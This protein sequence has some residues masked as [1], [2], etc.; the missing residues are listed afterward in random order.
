MLALW[1]GLGDTIISVAWTLSYEMYFYLLFGLALFL[2]RRVGLVL[3]ATILILGVGIGQGLGLKSPNP[4]GEALYGSELLLFLAGVAIGRVALIPRF[5][6]LAGLGLRPT[7]LA[8]VAAILLLAS[9]A[10]RT[11][12]MPPL[13]AYGP[14][15]VLLV[16]AAVAA[17]LFGRVHWTINWFSSLGDSSYALYLSHILTTTLLNA[18]VF[19]FS[20]FFGLGVGTHIIPLTAISVLLAHIFYLRVEKPL[21][22]F[23]R[24]TILGARP[25]S[26]P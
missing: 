7:A 20:E 17:D 8:T 21:Q 1:P 18:A 11:T 26:N 6:R 13:V 3:L 25:A 9:P 19:R 10:V 5:V 24:H 12:G 23:L 15:A 22:T 16:L 14:A 2:P 4:S